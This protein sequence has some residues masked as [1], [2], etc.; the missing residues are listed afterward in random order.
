[1]PLEVPLRV[2]FKGTFQ[3]K[4]KQVNQERTQMEISPYSK[5]FTNTE[6]LRVP[7]MEAYQEETQPVQHPPKADWKFQ[8]VLW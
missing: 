4:L 5:P 8:P 1:M 6:P 3:E 7:T 2:P